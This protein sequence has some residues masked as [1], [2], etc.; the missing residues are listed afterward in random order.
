LLSIGDSSKKPMTVRH[1]LT[2]TSGL[3]D[4]LPGNR[5][6]RQGRASLQDFCDGTFDVPLDF[7]PGRGVQYQSMGFVLLSRIIELASGRTI[8]DFV[9]QEIL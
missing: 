2:H 9:Q 5:E 6:L 1:L 4:M 3:P 8:H 7:P